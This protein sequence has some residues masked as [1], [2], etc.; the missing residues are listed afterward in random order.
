MTDP[1]R[2]IRPAAALMVGVLSGGCSVAPRS[3]LDECHTLSRGLR[4]ENAQLKDVTHRLRAH[5]QDLAQRAFDDARRLDELEQANRRLEQSV[6]AYREER[7]RLI[8]TFEQFRGALSAS[9]DHPDRSHLESLA[10]LGT[11]EAGASLEAERV[12]RES[13]ATQRLAAGPVDRRPPP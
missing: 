3:R 13:S 1:A 5:N 6:I 9:T 12:G 10:D 4:T 7:E 2:W 11:S 8:A